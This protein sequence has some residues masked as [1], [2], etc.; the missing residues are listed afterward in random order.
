MRA[1]APAKKE[2]NRHRQNALF[3]Q[4]LVTDD[5]GGRTLHLVARLA[6]LRHLHLQELHLRHVVGQFGRVL[7]RLDDQ[8]KEGDAQ[9]QR[10]DQDGRPPGQAHVDVQPL[11][12]TLHP[13]GRPRRRQT[14]IDEGRLGPRRRRGRRLRKRPR[15]R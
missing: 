11:H 3:V 12:G 1:A 7:L 4:I 2:T 9:H 8:R 10:A 6:R 14:Q 15:L 13:T 5:N